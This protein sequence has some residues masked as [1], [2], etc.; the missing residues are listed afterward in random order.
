MPISAMTPNVPHLVEFALPH[1]VYHGRPSHFCSPGI[2]MTHGKLVPFEFI[3]C[4]LK[5]AM[6]CVLGRKLAPRWKRL[7][8]SAFV[9]LGC[10]FGRDAHPG[11]RNGP[12]KWV[13]EVVVGLGWPTRIPRGGRYQCLRSC[14]GSH[15]VEIRPNSKKL[16]LHN[17]ENFVLYA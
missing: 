9:A 2:R 16:L 15:L 14:L 11:S 17:H 13:Q 12:Q 1:E 7:R 6:G 8:F 3:D 4:A 10:Q 5:L